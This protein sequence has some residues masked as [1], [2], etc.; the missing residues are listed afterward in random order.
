[1]ASKLSVN[2]ELLVWHERPEGML[3]MAREVLCLTREGMPARARE[4]LREVLCLTRK[5]HLPEC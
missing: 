5:I 1:M 4:Q 2:G 3:A